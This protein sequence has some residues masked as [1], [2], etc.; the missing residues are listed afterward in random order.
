MSYQSASHRAGDLRYSRR[1][2]CARASLTPTQASGLAARFICHGYTGDW[3]YVEPWWRFDAG[4]GGSDVAG[5]SFTQHDFYALQD[6]LENLP[7]GAELGQGFVAEWWEH[8]T[9][10]WAGRCR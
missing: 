9:T 5:A 3:G 1:T 10:V 7:Y 8:K 6:G 2:R 4:D